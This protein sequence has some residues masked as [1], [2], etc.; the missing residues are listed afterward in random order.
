MLLWSRLLRCIQYLLR[1]IQYLLRCIQYLLR[2]IQYLVTLQMIVI[3]NV[4]LRQ[5]GCRRSV[6]QSLCNLEALRPSHHPSCPLHLLLA[7]LG[8][9]AS[10]ARQLLLLLHVVVVP[11]QCAPSPCSYY[12][13][14]VHFAHPASVPV[15]VLVPPPGGVREWVRLSLLGFFSRTSHGHLLPDNLKR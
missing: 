14:F 5:Q 9:V 2:C 13:C 10:V 8:C 12:V 6:L 11:V 3:I 1:C 15:Q 4:Q 7:W